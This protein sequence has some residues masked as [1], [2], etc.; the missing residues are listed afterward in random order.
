MEA[1]KAYHAEVTKILSIIV[2]EEAEN[3]A[4]AAEVMATCVEQGK[5]IH[6]FGTG[7][8]SYMAGEEMFYRAGGLQPIN[9]ILDSGVSLGNGARRSTF[10]E[11]TPGYAKAVLDA[12]G[13]AEGEAMIIVNVN[14]INSLTIES[15]EESKKRG[16]TVI[17]VTSREF[18]LGVP[19]NTPSRHPSNANLFE[20]SDIV[21]DLHIPPGDALLTLPGVRPRVAAGSTV[22][23]AFVLNA[24]TAQT[25]SVLSAKG[26]EPPLW[27]SANLPGGDEANKEFLS[28]NISRIK[29]L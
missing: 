10:V 9:A 28:R 19:P 6:V 27:L 2:S 14:G 18:S 15:A 8:H 20:V 22:A 13:V 12:Y 1:V 11:R 25:V 7:G 21:I 16:L 5:L 23:V 3:I 24:L 4:K 26:I 29:H 17:G